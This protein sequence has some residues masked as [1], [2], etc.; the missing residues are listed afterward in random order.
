MQRKDDAYAALDDDF[1][2]MFG[3]MSSSL[4]L[5]GC[6]AGQRQRVSLCAR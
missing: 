4:L 1:K 3:F 5:Y 6:Y 2:A